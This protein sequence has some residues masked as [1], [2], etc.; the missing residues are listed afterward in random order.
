MRKRETLQHAQKLV[1]SLASDMESGKPPSP[2]FV[3]LELERISQMLE[4]VLKGN[5]DA[6]TY[7]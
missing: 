7:A 2:I 1:D 4:T 5:P 6:R 3:H